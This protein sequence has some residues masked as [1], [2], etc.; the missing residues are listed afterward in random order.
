MLRTSFQCKL[1]RIVFTTFDQ[2]SIQFRREVDTFSTDN[3]KLSEGL[4]LT[5]YRIYKGISDFQQN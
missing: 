5:A 1:L 3:S 2:G 4:A